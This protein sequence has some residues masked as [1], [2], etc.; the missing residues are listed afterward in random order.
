[1]SGLKSLSNKLSI[2]LSLN[3]DTKFNLELTNRNQDKSCKELI[4]DLKHKF[5]EIQN[6]Q[7]DLTNHVD[8]NKKRNN[9][10][11]REV[12]E[13]KE[14]YTI[15]NGLNEELK[16]EI[17]FFEEQLQRIQF[18]EADNFKTINTLTIQVDNLTAHNQELSRMFDPEKM[19]LLEEKIGEMNT[20]HKSFEEL[21][22]KLIEGL[23]NSEIGAL[24][25]EA[26]NVK[27]DLN[28]VK[29]EVSKFKRE[30][31]EDDVLDVDNVTYKK[32]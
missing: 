21:F 20:E 25:R 19:R 7:N 31:F 27:I 12:D 1:L 2:L 16:S 23:G 15:V 29:S 10:L 24:V 17:E 18:E 32:R 8:L 6:S 14:K 28:R 9:L 11:E 13:Y 22:D 26:Q 30:L 4:Q 3:D 5:N